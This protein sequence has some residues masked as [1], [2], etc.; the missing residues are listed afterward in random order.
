MC[1]DVTNYEPSLNWY[2]IPN[3]SAANSQGIQTL[4]STDPV[5]S[6]R[7][8]RIVLTSVPVALVIKRAGYT[9]PYRHTLSG[10]K[11]AGHHACHSVVA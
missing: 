4:R 1:Y 2:R 8:C 10:I 6:T 3:G 11:P 9:H 5:H 7:L